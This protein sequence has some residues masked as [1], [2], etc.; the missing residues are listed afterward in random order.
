[1]G[2]FSKLFGSYSERELKKIYPI[3]DKIEALDGEYSALT[4]SQLRDK[5]DEF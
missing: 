1:M 5:T 4:D 2:L 3:V